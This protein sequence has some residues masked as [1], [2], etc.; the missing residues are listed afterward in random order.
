MGREKAAR[1]TSILRFLDQIQNQSGTWLPVLENHPISFSSDF[2]PGESMFIIYKDLSCP[3]IS[4]IEGAA[5]FCVIL[6]PPHLHSPLPLQH[7]QLP[8]SFVKTAT[9]KGSPFLQ[10]C[11]YM[12]A[13]IIVL[14]TYSKP[15]NRMK[16]SLINISFKES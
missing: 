3:F 2:F 5:K 16:S 8:L 7:C 1:M 13:K 4:H 15:Y 9:T 10:S 6:L 14:F 11:L 12:A